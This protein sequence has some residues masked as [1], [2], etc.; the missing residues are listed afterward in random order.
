M[1]IFRMLLTAQAT[2][3]LGFL[4]YMG[5]VATTRVHFRPL[6][7]PNLP[8]VLRKPGQSLNPRFDTRRI[9]PIGL[10]TTERFK[11]KLKTSYGMWH[12]TQCRLRLS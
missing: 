8:V 2:A 5:L 3:I 4:G 11:G 10:C 1:E 6:L 12:D 7:G 9:H